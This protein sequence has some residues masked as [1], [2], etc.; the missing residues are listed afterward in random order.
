MNVALEFWRS[1]IGKKVTMAVTGIMMVLFLL[2][3]VSGNLLVFKGQKAMDDYAAFLQSLGGLLWLARLSLIAAVALHATAAYQ[4]TM[5]ARAARPQAYAKKKNQ[6]ATLASQL[7]RWGGVLI[8]VYIVFHIL[9]FTL[10]VVQ[11]ISHTEVYHNVVAGFSNP[12]ISL[13]YLV[14]MAFIGLHLYHGVWSSARTLGLSRPSLHP[15][16]RRLAIVLAVVV[17]AGF[18]IIPVAVL[19]GIVH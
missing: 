11:P 17:W 7:M 8:A 3:H 14:A 9:H 13:F 4:L 1:T 16:H 18:S 15:L 5:A 2:G 19:A 6:V 12:L 10:G